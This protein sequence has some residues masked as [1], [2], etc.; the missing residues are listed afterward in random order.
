MADYL[1]EVDHFGL[2]DDV[3]SFIYIQI[4]SREHQHVHGTLVE[5]DLQEYFQVLFPKQNLLMSS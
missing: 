4:T 1:E 5:S 2:S 3:A